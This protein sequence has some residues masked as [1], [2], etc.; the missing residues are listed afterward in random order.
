[1][2]I[3]W[4]LVQR[5]FFP[6]TVISL[7]LSRK[8]CGVMRPGLRASPGSWAV[9][10]RAARLAFAC[11]L[12]AGLPQGA[13]AQT[14]RTLAADSAIIPSGLGAGDSFRLLFVTSTTGTA[15]ATD[16]NAYNARVQAAAANGH[17]EIQAFSSEFRALAST[18]GIAARDN[19]RTNHV[20]ASDEDAPIYWLLGEK[21]ADDYADFYDTRWDSNVPRNEQ[22]GSNFPVYYHPEVNQYENSVKVYVWTGSDPDGS[23][24]IDNYLGNTNQGLS[25]KYGR[26]RITPVEITAGN[27]G[28]SFQLSLYALSPILTVNTPPVA[29]AGAGQSEKEGD[30]VTLDGSASMDNEGEITYLWAGTGA[31][32][33]I[34]LTGADTVMPTFIAPMVDAATDY[35]FRLTVT[36]DEGATA[37]AKVK[38]TIN[39]FS[40]NTR[41]IALA[42]NN[43]RVNRGVTVTL[44]GSR[45]SDREGEVT[46]HWEGKDDK[47]KTIMLSGADTATATFTAPGMPDTYTFTLT[48]TDS[49]G[50]SATADVHITVKDGSSSSMS[51]GA[52]TLID[53][54]V[55][56]E[57]TGAIDTQT[58]SAIAGRIEQAAP[59]G[60]SRDS[61]PRFNLNGQSTLGGVITDQWQ[62]LAHGETNGNINTKQ[63]LGNADFTLPL[64]VAVDDSGGARI[65]VAFWGRGGYR[66]M[67]GDSG[68]LDW[69]GEV[70]SVQL[71]LD[72]RLDQLLIGVATSWSQAELDYSL[73][74][75]AGA[76][77]AD[78]EGEYQLDLNSVNP[79]MGW[80]SRDGRMDLW[81][82]L[83]YG[84]GELTITP[85]V[86]QPDADIARDVTTRTVTVGASGELFRGGNGTSLRLK[87][88]ATKTATD[89]AGGLG[90]TQLDTD[91]TRVRLGLELSGEHDLEQGA[92]LTPSLELG[93]R[94]DGGDGNTGTGAVLGAGL[95]RINPATG[96]TLEG[97]FHALVG[98][99]DYAEWGIEGLIRVEGGRDG[100]GLSFTL[101][102]GYGNDNVG[103]VQQ[104]WQREWF[105]AGGQDDARGHD[106]DYHARINLRLGYGLRLRDVRGIFTPYSEMTLGN[107]SSSHRLG[108]RWQSGP[109]F[110]LDLLTEQARRDNSPDE[111]SILLQGEVLF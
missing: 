19:T 71:G 98:R 72:T 75:A 95:R 109:W 47:T 82:S 60:T 81:L 2:K 23:R 41:P 102:P 27:F 58:A 59:G 78:V 77:Q 8:N 11:L 57:V 103:S 25:V 101:S 10:R 32:S 62:A 110:N 91:A 89:L 67:N 55:L 76:Q 51:P 18:A 66:N 4:S 3:L 88:E 87:G 85:D 42:G 92:Q 38:I 73:R 63:L 52:S 35:I 6:L 68:E 105:D 86:S 40:G 22:G 79:Y 7:P 65:P 36:D 46:Y 90:I 94:Y 107:A 53:A 33:T 106:R 14:A 24:S 83:G 5:L 39:D 34:T 93:V 50:V 17:I 21:V 37:T 48:V 74:A 13:V 30:M 28:N 29:D 96:L 45:S 80:S 104:V 26:P 31:A 49:N 16:I 1:M 56:P 70:F 84:K 99:D 64:K 111:R 61:S 9:A 69:G 20:T 97:K 100:R 54:S 43:R 15:I 12:L 44:D 108:V